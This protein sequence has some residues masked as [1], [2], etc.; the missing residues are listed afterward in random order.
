MTP[1]AAAIGGAEYPTFRIPR[2]LPP[3]RRDI[4]DAGIGGVDQHLGDVVRLRETHVRPAAPRVGGAEHPC[5]GIGI[6]GIARLRL[7]G[8]D[9]HDV[10]VA[11][12]HRHVADRECALVLE[13][14]APGEAVVDGLPEVPR[15]DAGVDGAGVPGRDCDRLDARADLHGAGRPPRQAAEP[16]VICHRLVAGPRGGAFGRSGRLR[17]HCGGQQARQQRDACAGGHAGRGHRCLT[18]RPPISAQPHGVRP[19]EPVRIQRLGAWHG[20]RTPPAGLPTDSARNRRT[21]SRA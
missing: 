8:A 7:A 14:R 17:D 11:A 18:M 3:Q 15:S 13:D 12:R 10:G 5:T 9:P 16:A 1:G 2:P 6:A 4:H 19:V 21:A 20:D